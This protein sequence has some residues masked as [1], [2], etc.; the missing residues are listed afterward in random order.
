MKINYFFAILFLPLSLF[1]QENEI[2]TLLLD[3]MIV[4]N[5][6]TKVSV[7]TKINSDCSLVDEHYYVSPHS[8]APNMTYVT[9]YIL[10]NNGKPEIFFEVYNGKKF[11]YVKDAHVTF[12]K[13]VDRDNIKVTLSRRTVDEKAFLHANIQQI[14]DFGTRYFVEEKE[15]EMSSER[16]EAMQPFFEVEKYGIGF[17]KYN[18]TEG[19]SSTG[20][21]FEIFNPSKKT[22]KYIWFTFAG[23]NAVEDLVKMKNGTYYTTVKGIGP[24][25][26]YGIGSWSFEYVWFTDIIQYLRLSTIK[27]QYMDGSLKTVKYNKDMYIGE[28]AYYQLEKVLNEKDK[29][30]EEKRKNELYID[31]NKIYTEVEQLVEFPGG[32]SKFRS[33]VSNNFNTSAMDGGEG[34][35]KSTISFVVERDGSITDVKADGPNK[36]FNAEA[37]RAVKSVKNKWSPAKINGQAVRYQYRLPLTMSF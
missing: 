13:D 37:I 1:A 3:K 5:I 34:V 15:L 20:A 10:C 28:D 2:D 21:H 29:Y 17:I 33:S 4:A 8:Q 30:V 16:S 35:V 36:S 27:I 31:T 22:I 25:E 19:Y 26:S 32:I 7:G 11:V 14:V 6:D 24:I 18:A 23:E 12:N 9:D